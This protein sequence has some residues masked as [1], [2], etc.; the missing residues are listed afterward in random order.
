MITKLKAKEMNKIAPFF[1]AIKETLIWSCLQGV[2]GTAYVVDANHPTCAQIITAD[3]CFFAGDAHSEQAKEL[4]RHIPIEYAQRSL[5]A[6][7]E[8]QEWE[9]LIQAC[10]G[11]RI[12]KFQRYAIKKDV[13]HFDIHHLTKLSKGL[14]N[15]YVIEKIDE[16][17][18][19]ETLKHAWSCD[20][21]G[22]FISA[23]DFLNRG[24]GFV[25]MKDKEIVAGASSYTVYKEGIEIEI[26]T[27]P[28]YRKQGLATAVGATLVLYCLENN[29]YP[30][31]D[32]H[33][34]TSVH[35]AEKLGYVFDHEYN[36]FEITNS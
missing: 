10:Y 3:F 25:V 18:Y 11:E 2:M 7:L 23:E 34:L 32:A 17:L 8:N 21:C 24:I 1:D 33:N 31:W 27:A 14:P 9:E 29:L 36:T 19:Y 35:L 22:N 28:D 12:K 30:S 13:H 20:L 6:I 5:F 26:D 15:Q 16:A 4:I